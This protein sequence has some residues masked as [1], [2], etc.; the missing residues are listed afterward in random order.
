MAKNSGKQFEEDFAHSFDDREFFVYRLKDSA[1]SYNKT[2]KFTW[3]QPVDFFVFSQRNKTLFPCECKSTRYTNISYDNPY[4][5]KPESKMV[6]RHQILEME[7]MSK[8][9]GIEPYFIFN[10]REVGKDKIQVTYIQSI[11]H[12]IS[13]IENINNKKSFN[14]MDLSLNGAV[15]IAG[16]KKHTRYRWKI[17]EYFGNLEID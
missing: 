7:K 2:A 5:N 4:D 11:G 17:G 1:Q 8:Y 10:F 13:M 9:K 12:F 16:E 3:S 15:R 6:K 14:L